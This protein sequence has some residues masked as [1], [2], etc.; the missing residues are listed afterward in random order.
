MSAREIPANQLDA[1]R[2]FVAA[3]AIEG[4]W[5]PQ[6]QAISPEDSLYLN[7]TYLL[8]FH[9]QWVL[10]VYFRELRPALASLSYPKL[11]DLSEHLLLVRQKANN[12]AEH[13]GEQWRQQGYVVK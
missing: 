7:Q 12:L 11:N 3:Y 5:L 10:R 1:A 13:M 8:Y 6:Q 4:E 2:N 9:I